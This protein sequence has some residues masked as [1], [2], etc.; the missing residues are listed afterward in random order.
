MGYPQSF[1][2]IDRWCE[3]LRRTHVGADLVRALEERIDAESDPERLQILNWFLAGEYE[4]QGNE[5]AV[6]AIH[7]RDP[8]AEIHRWHQE[9]QQSQPDTDIIPVLEDRIRRETH[10]SR[11]HTLRYFLAD[12][13]R[14]RANYVA[15]E[16]VFLAD[17]EADPARPMPLIFLAGQKLY[18][19]EQPE[20]A[21]PVI[22]RAVEVAL[23]SGTFRRHALGVKARIALALDRHDVV[24]DVL[25]QIMALAFTRGN[26]D[27]GAERDFLDRLPPGSI[28]ADVARAYDEYCRERGALPEAL[29][30][31]IDD[32]ILSSAAAQW[33]NVAG[34]ISD[35]LSTC[36]RDKVEISEFAIGKR[37]RFLVE[38]DKLQAKGDL[39]HP[40]DS[41][42][43]LPD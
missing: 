30:Q 20:A 40:R 16:A 1:N 36:E 5:A 33:R 38:H 14:D 15:S 27:I 10:P 9:W 41:E 34:I 11:L 39:H 23:R 43:K 18:Y 26:A 2:E 3:E 24:E 42:V 8:A 25:R 17:F 28:D 6:E 31:H 7:R 37:V 32:L 12:A 35:V 19:E 4:A 29:E 13:H 22:D 21:M